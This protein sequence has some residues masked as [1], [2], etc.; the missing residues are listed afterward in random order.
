MLAHKTNVLY[1]T[2]LFPPCPPHS[3]NEAGIMNG[4][5]QYRKV[6]NILENLVENFFAFYMTMVNYG[7][8]GY[9]SL[10]LPN[11]YGRDGTSKSNTCYQTK[12]KPMK[13]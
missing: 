1:D 8:Y 6:S 9:L 5:G 2:R 4:T 13:F 12:S 11:Y 3:R 10:K 7:I